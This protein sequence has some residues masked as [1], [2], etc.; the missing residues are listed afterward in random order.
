MIRLGDESKI[1][2]DANTPA[3]ARSRR[4]AIPC[5]LASVEKICAIRKMLKVYSN[6]PRTCRDPPIPL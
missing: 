1:Y 5:M 3:H 2:A 4:I 6:P